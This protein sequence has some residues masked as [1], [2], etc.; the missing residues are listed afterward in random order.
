MRVDSET[1]QRDHEPPTQTNR[2]AQAERQHA[3]ATSTADHAATR[4]LAY[5]PAA[6][7]KLDE[8]DYRGPLTAAAYCAWNQVHIFETVRNRIASVALPA[9]HVR[10]VW[11]EPSALATAFEHALIATSGTGMDLAHRLPELIYP[12]DV[13]AIVDRHR[14]LVEGRAGEELDGKPARGP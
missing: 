6:A 7:P 1:Q 12:V 5:Q 14:D 11:A 3:G 4:S 2:V 9:P 8:R 13:Y 10:L